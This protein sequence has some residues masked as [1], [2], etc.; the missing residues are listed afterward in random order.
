MGRGGGGFLSSSL[1]KQDVK[2]WKEKTE[3]KKKK[4]TRADCIKKC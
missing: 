1:P 2:S 4:N 3:T